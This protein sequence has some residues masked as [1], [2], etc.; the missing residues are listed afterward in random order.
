MGAIFGWMD[1]LKL[2][3]LGQYQS[4]QSLCPKPVTP[5]GKSD[6]VF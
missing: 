3:D 5:K 2:S 1:I 6:T 4:T